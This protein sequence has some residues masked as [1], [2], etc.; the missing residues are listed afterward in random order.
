MSYLALAIVF[1]CGA[2]A[3]WGKSSGYLDF[4]RFFHWMTIQVIFYDAC[5]QKREYCHS[6]E[7]PRNFYEN[8]IVEHDTEKEKTRNSAVFLLVS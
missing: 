7:P 1:A 6:S 4:N 8:E 3:G 5:T 2:K